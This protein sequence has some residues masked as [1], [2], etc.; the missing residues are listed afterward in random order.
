MDTLSLAKTF[1]SARLSLWFIAIMLANSPKSIS[2]L[3]SRR[4]SRSG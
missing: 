1:S 2:P 4:V 3:S